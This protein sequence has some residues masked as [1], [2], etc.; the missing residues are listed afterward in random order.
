M[1]DIALMS[2]V[3]IWAVYSLKRPWLGV[4][5]WVFL[6]I[7]N[8]H[9]FTFGFAYNAPVAQ[10]AAIAILI[11]LVATKERS[12][13]FKGVPVMWMGVFTVWITLS[14]LFGL[15]PGG[16][17]YQWNKVMK[18]FLMIFVGL[19]L[20]HDKKHIIALAWATGGSMALL[21]AKGGY[22]T[23]VTGGNYRVWGPAGSFIEDNNE[24]A[25]AC[26]MAIPLLRFLQMQLSVAWQRHAMT[27]VMV[28][29]AAAALG[30]HSR[31]SFLALVA[32][33]AVL[34]W[35]GRNRLVMVFPI[36]VI[37]ISLIAFMP[38]S[39]VNRMESINDYEQ[40]VSARGRFSAWWTA[41][42]VAK[43]YPFGAGFFVARP[44]LFAAYSP[45]WAEHTTTHA[46][47]SIYFQVLGNH[48]FVGLFIFLMVWASSWSSANWTRKHSAEHPDARWAGDLAAMAQVSLV[49]Y[50]V[51][52]A[53]L[54]LSYFDLPYNVMM[55]I[56]LSRVWVQTKA[57]QREPVYQPGWR[58]LPGLIQPARGG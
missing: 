18:V 32:M 29:T 24:F 31:G 25:L 55:L 45:Y 9:R 36:L 35:R 26:V 16:D 50:A 41:F 39:W 34:W 8:P 2:L 21:G 57:W 42:G 13:P 10:I 58:T 56:V 51:G 3:V 7:A 23:L 43:N 27:L 6:S 53:F 14:W 33:G 38:D 44:E 40:D 12:S 17:Y 11:G 5:L 49:G 19:A 52:G 22:F 30:T 28:L 47:H 15:S 54:S 46:A 1:R 20:L 4:M 37:G 48:G